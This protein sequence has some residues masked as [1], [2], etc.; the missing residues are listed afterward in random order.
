[1]NLVSIVVPIYNAERYVEDCVKSILGQSYK[2]IE[3]LLIDDGSSDL[4]GKIIDKIAEKDDRVKVFHLQNVGVAKARNYGIEHATGKYIAFSDS[5]DLMEQSFVEKAVSVIDNVDYVSGA[6]ET[7]D[8]NRNINLIDYMMM[9]GESVSCTDYLKKMIE[10]QAGAYWGANW[11]KLYRSD[12]I[13]KNNLQ[14]EPGVNFAEDF[15]FNIQYLKHVHKIGLIHDTVYYYRIDTN[16]SLS[17]KSREPIQYWNEYYELYNRYV[18]L[19]EK[20]GILQETQNEISKFLLGAYIAVIRECI[21]CKNM[22][23]KDVIKICELLE[24]NEKVQSAANRYTLLN[25]RISKYA[26]LISKH[27]GKWIAIILKIMDSLKR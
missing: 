23:L 6:F 11:G 27:N 7:F 21:S 9:F 15:R 24:S 19:Y 13:K 8:E 4:S 10:Y 14:F 17:K 22:S 25:G 16:G 12:I 18:E 3:V 2:D 5:D 26:K 20:H 1:M